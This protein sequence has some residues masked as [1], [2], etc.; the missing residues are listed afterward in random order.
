MTVASPLFVARPTW[1]TALTGVRSTNYVKGVPESKFVFLGGGSQNAGLLFGWYREAQ[2]PIRYLG[3]P[4]CITYIMFMISPPRCRSGGQNE[5]LGSK[6]SL[7]QSDLTNSR[8]VSLLVKHN[9]K[10][11]WFP[12]AR[13]PFVFR[14]RDTTPDLLRFA[15]MT[16]NLGPTA[17]MP[18]NQ[19]LNYAGGWDS[20]KYKYYE[21]KAKRTIVLPTP[22]VR[23]P[24][25]C[26]LRL[27]DS[28]RRCWFCNG[29]ADF[30]SSAPAWREDVLRPQN[31]YKQ[32]TW[33][34]KRW[35][36]R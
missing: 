35:S 34:I 20:L 6:D 16:I 15:C 23:K 28:I 33:C 8:F 13:K 1:R 10:W 2:K 36:I 27:L 24:T 5:T 9:P 31:S 19:L 4:L 26:E 12:F 32:Q 29:Y 3:F 14:S 17:A 18:L 25:V 21:N 7:G 22:Q 30:P 11:M